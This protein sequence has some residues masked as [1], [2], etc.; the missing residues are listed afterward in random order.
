[1]MGVP[2]PIPATGG[3]QTGSAGIGVGAG[4]AGNAAPTRVPEAAAPP[5]AEVEA[6]APQLRVL[7]NAD[8]EIA[9][10]AAPVPVA[11][12]TQSTGSGIPESALRPSRTADVSHRS[13]NTQDQ[14]SEAEEKVVSLRPEAEKG[15]LRP[16]AKQEP[17]IQ[18]RGG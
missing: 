17:G 5:A 12:V 9:A 13:A 7:P 8:P 6:A 14:A 10:K 11:R 2:I 18:M 1:M 16:R 15:K 4:S 3:N